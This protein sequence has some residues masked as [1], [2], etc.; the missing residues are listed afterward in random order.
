MFSYMRCSSCADFQKAI[1]ADNPF[2]ICL[3]TD[4]PVNSSFGCMNWDAKVG[5]DWKNVEEED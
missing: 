4:Q 2:G 1:G 5:F 3:D